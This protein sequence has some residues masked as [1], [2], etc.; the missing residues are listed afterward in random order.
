MVTTGK[1]LLAQ[2]SETPEIESG[3]DATLVFGAFRGVLSPPQRA[4]SEALC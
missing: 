2:S 4:L 1:T 3:E